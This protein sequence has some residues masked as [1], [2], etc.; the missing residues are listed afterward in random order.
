MRGFA[1]ATVVAALLHLGSVAY[2][3]PVI[4]VVWAMEDVTYR[5]F[6]PIKATVDL[7]FGK[8]DLAQANAK[9]TTA[10]SNFKLYVGTARLLPTRGLSI[11][12]IDGTEILKISASPPSYDGTIRVLNND[13]IIVDEGTITL[14]DIL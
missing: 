2:A 5:G 10:T 8:S 7:E 1:I 14:D 9:L 3:D 13:Q 6:T 12:L 4:Q 11:T